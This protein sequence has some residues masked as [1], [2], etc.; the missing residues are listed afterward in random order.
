MKN[1]LTTDFRLPHIGQRMIKTSIAVFFCLLVYRMLGYQGGTMPA[2]A[3]ITAIICMQPFIND[4][5]AFAINRFTGTIVGTVWGMMFL[6]LLSAVPA[7]GHHFVILYALM[8]IGVLGS[9]YTS[10]AMK[11][12]DISGLAA[13]V[14]MCIVVQFPDIEAPFLEA[15][16]R[17]LG[18]MIGTT[19][20]ILINVAHLPR[21]K[22]EN[23]VFFIRGKDLTPNRFSKVSP[24]VLFHMNQLYEDG[25][26]ICIML[27][28][29]PAL[30]TMQM[31]SCHLNMPL[32]V[33]DGAAIYDVSENRYLAVQNICPETSAWLQNW[34]RSRSINFFTY[35]INQNR[36]C[37]YHDG[38]MNE[39]EIQVLKQLQR[40]PYRSYLE[41]ENLC[42]EEI[43]YL[44]VLAKDADLAEISEELKPQ[45]MKL[46]LRMVIRAQASTPGVSGLY[47]FSE[48]ADL[49]TAK[50]R[51]LDIMQI[52]YPDLQPV[53]VYSRSE[54]YTEQG[55]AS[56][57]HRL[58]TAYEPMTIPF[59]PELLHNK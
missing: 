48:T 2:E 5:R 33:M 17:F 14:F 57:L 56:L 49:E 31:S 10:V 8:G 43:V 24:S 15:A 27:E 39:L 50:E 44:K 53:D 25:A 32:I 13:I 7:L 54:T 30:F 34:F 23:H 36:T 38:I 41:G 1:F 52:K 26:K 19:V 47:I 37:I 12:S 9:V 35:V 3:A 18:V 55:A 16:R 20:A 28:H 51:Y 46:P 40:S 22:K 45:L 11:V 29:A 21:R 4:S 59:V 58:R 42:P 6:L